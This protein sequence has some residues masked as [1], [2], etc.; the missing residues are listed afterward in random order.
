MFLHP[1]YADRAKAKAMRDFAEWVLSQRAQNYGAQLGYLPLSADITALGK[2]AL[3]G[4]A[5]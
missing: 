3:A 2:D 5:Y 1:H 4:L